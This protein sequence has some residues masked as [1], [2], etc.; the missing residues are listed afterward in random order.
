MTEVSESSQNIA[1]TGK[2]TNARG[3]FKAPKVMKTPFPDEFCL[4]SPS[5]SSNKKSA[6]RVS[7]KREKEGANQKLK[8]QECTDVDDML[9]DFCI[10][11][12]L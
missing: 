9:N 7:V 11:N 1:Q 12:P 5:L 2:D 8:I 6:S 3:G 4:P 10:E